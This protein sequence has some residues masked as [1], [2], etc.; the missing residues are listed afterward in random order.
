MTEINMDALTESHY[1]KYDPAFEEETEED[2]KAKS[3]EWYIELDKQLSSV[4]Y[5]VLAQ[6]ESDGVDLS[7]FVK[8]NK[9]A[10]T[11]DLYAEME[12]YE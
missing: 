8:E 12:E 3:M 7:E 11:D 2:K 6:A 5:H 4:L 1:A 9:D 10:I